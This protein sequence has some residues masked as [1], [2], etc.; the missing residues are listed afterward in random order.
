MINFFE[1][2]KEGLH[3]NKF[4]LNDTICVE[5]T[6][7]IE[8]EQ[9]IG[10]CSQSDYLIYILSGKKTWKTIHGEWTLEAGSTIYV[11]KGATLIDQF[12]ENEFCVLAF[13]ISDDLI[14]ESV[15]HH[16]ELFYQGLILPKPLHDIHKKNYFMITPKAEESLQSRHA[17]YH[18]EELCYQGLIQTTSLHDI[19]KSSQGKLLRDK[20]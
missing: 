2:V 9:R 19:H 12:F 6:C 3:F 13:F 16:E 4:E 15:F 18:T 5:Y 10:L 11:K 7:P 20:T 17:V 1:T 8:N 14:Q